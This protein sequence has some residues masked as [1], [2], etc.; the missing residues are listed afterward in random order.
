MT[1][2]EIYRDLGGKISRTAIIDRDGEYVIQGKYCIAAPEEG[3]IFD[4][5]I[6]NP[7][8]MAAGLG[9]KRVRNMLRA[10]KTSVGTTFRELTGEAW[11]KVAGTD[12]IL[13]NAAILG[14]RR[15]RK[16]SPEQIASMTQRIKNS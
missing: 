13:A 9:Q 6:C 16:I 5:F 12:E 2:D 11:A 3:G 15:K 7:K 1:K 14:I 8:N 10:W 4:V